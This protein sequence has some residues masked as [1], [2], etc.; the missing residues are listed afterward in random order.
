MGGFPIWAHHFKRRRRI[1]VCNRFSSEQAP[2]LLAIGGAVHRCKT[3]ASEIPR[4]RHTSDVDAPAFCS[5]KIPIIWSS[6]NRLP[7]I[8]S[9]SIT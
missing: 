4:R 7:F 8:L 5:F 6:L 2:S 9:V 1:D 3:F